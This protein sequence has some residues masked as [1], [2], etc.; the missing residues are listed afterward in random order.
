MSHGLIDLEELP[1]NGVNLEGVS[2]AASAIR[3]SG[4]TIQQGGTDVASAWAALPLS[5]ETTGAEAIYAAMTPVRTA[6]D[7][8][9]S[10][11]AALARAMDEWVSTVQ[12]LLHQRDVLVADAHKLHRDVKNFDPTFEP[13]GNLAVSFAPVWVSHWW[14]DPTLVSRNNALIGRGY[15]LGEKLRVAD[16]NLANAIRRAAHL[17]TTA[18]VAAA[19]S[20]PDGVKTPWGDASAREE[21]C[22][23]KVV[24]FPAHLEL[25]IGNGAW[26]LL[27]GIG[28]LGGGYDF[29]S[30]PPPEWKLAGDLLSGN[31][32]QYMTDGSSWLSGWGQA[33]VGLGHLV[34]GVSMGVTGPLMTEVIMP[35]QISALKSQGADTSALEGLRQWERDSF[36]SEVDLFGSFVGYHA[37]QEWWKA[38]GDDWAAGW[39]DWGAD[40]GGTAGNSVFNIATLI[41]P[42]KGGGAILDS[43]KGARVGIDGVEGASGFADDAGRLTSGELSSAAT[44]LDGAAMRVDA[45]VNDASGFGSASHDLGSALGSSPLDN[46]GA[47]SDRL[48]TDDPIVQHPVAPTVQPHAPGVHAPEPI[49]PHVEPEPQAPAVP[50]DAPLAQPVDSP[51]QTDAGGGEGGVDA[52]SGDPGLAT[53]EPAPLHPGLNTVD[54]RDYIVLPDGGIIDIAHDLP[55]AS[56]HI[57]K[58]DPG[59]RIS[60]SEG[61]IVEGDVVRLPHSDVE[62]PRTVYDKLLQ[63]AVHFRDG[64][65]LVLGKF[66][67]YRDYAEAHQLMHFDLGN[68]WEA[69]Q[70]QTGWNDREMFDLFNVDALREAQDAGKTVWLT[71]TPNSATGAF[72]WEIEWMK[73]AGWTLKW[74]PEHRQWIG[75][76]PV[77]E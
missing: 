44:D 3:N 1:G 57:D 43:L 7:R 11:L 56:A 59:A 17:S 49:A 26:N 66:P 60:A 21:S 42:V 20:A 54:G 51:I 19:K 72:G 46:A 55:P 70:K 36:T 68:T 38:S 15:L 39:A 69:I 30:W 65:H 12:P 50:H 34:T 71:K 28:M 63:T 75:Y 13:T 31:L 23:E 40:P 25:G 6:S 61:P 76:P 62:L 27:G 37:P 8:L 10:N 5:Y 58:L 24:G 4:S 18:V 41:L 47:F 73:D 52:P 33:W 35:S 9:G 67:R 22:A 32:Q 29:K 53:P 64:T 74:F 16:E 14:E 2:A 48:L 77:S 45:L